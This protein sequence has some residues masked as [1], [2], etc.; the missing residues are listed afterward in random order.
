MKF[1]AMRISDRT[2]VHL[3]PIEWTNQH[4]WCRFN[5][6]DWDWVIIAQKADIDKMELPMC[7]TCDEWAT[8]QERLIWEEEERLQWMRSQWIRL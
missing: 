6:G 8:R 7:K 2:K 1:R 4:A 5:I 3:A